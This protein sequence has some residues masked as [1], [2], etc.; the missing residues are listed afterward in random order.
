[1]EDSIK[2]SLASLQINSLFALLLHDGDLLN[3]W[4]N[5]YS[6]KVKA[7]KKKKKIKYFGVSIYTTKEFD[8]AVLN[9]D[10]DIIQI[11]FNIFDQRAI[12]ENWFERAKENDK[13]LFIRSVY[14]Q[15]DCY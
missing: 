4:N 2:D 5:N 10:I 6:N 15:R 8:L 1:M 7:L 13:L 14:L 12:K 3:S 9:K 11:P